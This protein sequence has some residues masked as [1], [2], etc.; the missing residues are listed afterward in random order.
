VDGLPLWIDNSSS[1][2]S[3]SFEKQRAA[4]FPEQGDELCS[5]PSTSRARSFSRP[6][7]PS[8][9]EFEGGA[10]LLRGTHRPPFPYI[11][12]FVPEQS[13]EAVPFHERTLSVQQPF[14]QLTHS[15]EREKL[16]LDVFV[17]VVSPFPCPPRLS[18]EL[19]F[20]VETSED[21]SVGRSRSF[22]VVFHFQAD[23]SPFW[24]CPPLRNFFFEEG[25]ARLFF[26]FCPHLS[27]FFLESFQSTTPRSSCA[28]LRAGA[29][30]PAAF[31]AICPFRKN[32]T[33]IQVFL[34]LRTSS[35]S[36]F[37]LQREF[38]FNR[39]SPPAGVHHES[40]SR[41]RFFPDL[42]RPALPGAARFERRAFPGLPPLCL[43]NHKGAMVLL[44]RPLSSRGF[45]SPLERA[46]PR[47]GGSI[48]FT[49]RSLEIEN[50]S[51][52]L[53]SPRPKFLQP[54]IDHSSGKPPLLSPSPQSFTG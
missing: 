24:G 34:G 49:P 9:E 8:V 28:L 27:P 17:E 18:V 41:D 48:I 25:A 36:P 12:R 47:V 3:C 39:E 22:L 53:F 45:V 6:V 5:S 54:S 14:W 15:M 30:S 7:R 10:P 33:R 52:T 42:L 21:L 2:L 11:S 50:P 13:G 32:F 29:S 20:V 44:G 40:L 35:R 51:R 23:I 26:L 1:G 16:L 46:A 4:P 38:S 31:S 19:L 43:G 37:H